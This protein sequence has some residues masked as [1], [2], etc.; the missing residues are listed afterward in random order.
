MKLVIQEHLAVIQAIDTGLLS[1]LEG[2]VSSSV[3]ALQEGNKLLFCGNGG[4]AADAQ[5][6]AAEFVVRFQKNRSALSALSLATDTSAL[7]ACGND[8]NFDEIFARQV[9]AIGKAGDL[10]FAISTSG[11][12][13]NVLRAAEVA[14]VNNLSVVAITGQSESKLGEIADVSLKMPSANTARIQ[15]CYMLLGHILCG[16]IE[17]RMFL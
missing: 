17:Q 8:F 15:E 10:L 7:T 14:K 4:S 5:H 6:L 2:V 9:E 13:R 3:S 11:T 16:E 1:Q 12:S